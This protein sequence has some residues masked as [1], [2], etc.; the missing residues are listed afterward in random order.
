MVCPLYVSWSGQTDGRASWK[1]SRS[2]QTSRRT[3]FPHCGC[4]CEF[5]S[6]LFLWTFYR[7]LRSRIQKAFLPSVGKKRGLLV[8]SEAKKNTYVGPFVDLKSTSTRVAFAADV[9]GKGLITR[10][11][12]LMGFQVAF[13][14][15]LFTAVV[16][17]AGKGTFSSL[18]RKKSNQ[19]QKRRCDYKIS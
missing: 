9:A 13:C 3:A 16:K 6:F 10:M 15:E 2:C 19:I 11:D 8:S 17:L 7:N 12:Q 14:D 5:S 18:E 4:V 1:S